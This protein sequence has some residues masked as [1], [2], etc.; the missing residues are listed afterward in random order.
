MDRQIGHSVANALPPLRHFFDRS[1]VARRLNEARWAPPTRYTLWRNTVSIMKDL[2]RFFFRIGL[3]DSNANR[4]F[5]RLSLDLSNEL[6]SYPH[7]GSSSTPLA[8]TDSGINEDTDE[9][10][11]MLL[12]MD[13]KGLY[14]DENFKLPSLEI[15][16]RSLGMDQYFDNFL[17]NGC[18]SIE[19]VSQLNSRYT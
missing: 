6:R 7:H 11:A 4:Q 12:H 9:E 13:P 18:I 5:V 17:R 2:I 19:Q 10:C 16:L 8:A 15:W 14:P 1:S 3:R